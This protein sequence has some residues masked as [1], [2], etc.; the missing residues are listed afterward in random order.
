LRGA[1]ETNGLSDDL[2]HRV[3]DNL[4]ARAEGKLN[5][6]ALVRIGVHNIVGDAAEEAG[7]QAA[8]NADGVRVNLVRV[9]PGNAS[10][11]NPARIA[12]HAVISHQL[13]NDVGGC[14]VD[15]HRVVVGHVVRRFGKLAV[16]VHINASP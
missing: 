16:R 6:D 1:I 4:R 5:K 9:D 7:R 2:V 15:A 8:A 11:D 3:I 13:R 12:Q 10:R 14:G